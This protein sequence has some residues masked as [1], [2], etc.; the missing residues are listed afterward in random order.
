MMLTV[1]NSQLYDEHLINS[2]RYY[3]SWCYSCV[4]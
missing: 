4:L 1:Q 3:D 2:F